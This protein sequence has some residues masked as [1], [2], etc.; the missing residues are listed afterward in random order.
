MKK[1][2]SYSSRG[3]PARESLNSE[4]LCPKCKSSQIHERNFTKS[5]S[6]HCISCNNS[7]RLQYPTLI[8]GQIM[9]TEN[10]QT[11]KLPQN[12]RLENNFP[13]KWSQETS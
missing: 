7:G 8:N 5:Q 6:T 11:Q 9:D 1:D 3:N 12:K 10:K 2:T 4:H 13:S